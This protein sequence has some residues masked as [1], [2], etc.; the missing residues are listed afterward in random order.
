VRPIQLRYDARPTAATLRADVLAITEWFTDAHGAA[1]W[2]RSV[3]ALLA[4]EILAEL[5]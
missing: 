4:E 3:S 1:D 2:R 5:A